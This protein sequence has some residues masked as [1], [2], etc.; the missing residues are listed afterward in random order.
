MTGLPPLPTFWELA[1]PADWT[2]IDLISDLHLA[3]DMPRTFEAWAAH[4]RDTPAS[5]VFILGDL[6]EVWIGDDARHAGFE[7]RCADVLA[8]AASRITV[9]FMCGNRDFL[10]GGE[11]LRDC[12]V[13]ALPDPT[14][15]VAFGE[16]LLLSHGDALC[17]DDH[18]YQRF[19]TQVRSL[20][21]QRDFLARPL[22]ERREIARGMREHSE[23]RKTRQP[24]ADWIDIDR[25]TAVRWMH[26]ASTPTLIHGHTHRPAHED[27]APGFVREVLSDW[28]LD[29][30]GPGRAEVMRLRRAGLAR[31]PLG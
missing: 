31:I 29:H 11:L 17:L 20:A 4:L 25:A 30:A 2:A 23:Q 26:E 3:P 18:E 24:V 22:A 8:E 21:W 19:R 6:F 13:R 1:A 9:A 5:A 12:G 27:L 16:R 7:A 10:V 28:D 14:V 15:L